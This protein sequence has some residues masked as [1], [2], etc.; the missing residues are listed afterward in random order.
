MDLVFD[1]FIFKT[2][3]FE[4]TFDSF[5]KS[6][7]EQLEKNNL[8]FCPPALPINVQDMCRKVFFK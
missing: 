5:K 7:F 8:H 3:V 1:F 6:A 4:L 2:Q